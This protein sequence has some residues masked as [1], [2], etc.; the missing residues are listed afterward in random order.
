MTIDKDRKYVVD[1]ELEVAKLRLEVN[2]TINDTAHI[3]NEAQKIR[4]QGYEL[5]YKYARITLIAIVLNILLWKGVVTS[6]EFLQWIK[7]IL[8]I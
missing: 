6:S 7:R 4:L 5:M 3:A 1:K 8:G 2:R